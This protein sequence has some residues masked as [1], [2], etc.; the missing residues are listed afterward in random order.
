MKN[1]CDITKQPKWPRWLDSL[2]QLLFAAPPGRC[3]SNDLPQGLLRGN[4]TMPGLE[5]SS[6]TEIFLNSLVSALKP[7]VIVAW[8]DSTNCSISALLCHS[9][10]ISIS[11]FF[12]CVR[13]KSG[14]GP[15]KMAADV[16]G[17]RRECNKRAVVIESQPCSGALLKRH[18]SQTCW[19]FCIAFAIKKLC[20]PS[21]LP[22]CRAKD[23]NWT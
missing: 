22:R 15:N 21:S 8:N 11:F 16:R 17:C 23:L 9:Q 14:Q 12:F 19:A 4:G 6:V 2:F 20:G 1:V 5:S 7:P 13:V 3:D 10:R 18:Q